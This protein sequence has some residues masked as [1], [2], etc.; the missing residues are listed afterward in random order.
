M[1]DP[2]LIP[3]PAG[4]IETVIEHPAGTARGLALVAHPHPLYGGSMGNKVV[5]T[6]AR[7][8][9]ELGYITVRS[10]FRGVGQT[11][12]QYDEGMGETEDLLAVAR[13]I[14]ARHP[15]LAWS[16]LGFSFG[17]F[18]VQ[19]LSTRLS[20]TRLIMVAPAVSLR[21][22]TAPGAPAHIFQGDADEIIPV[23][24]VAEYAGRINLPLTLIPGAGHF[25]H[26]KLID[27]REAVRAVI[28]AP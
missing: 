24:A 22:F 10:N 6:L 23:A 18:V 3:G 13:F 12:G 17:A 11:E 15:D 27:L 8:L 16:L 7:L 4:A 25:F 2:L 14:H 9:R 26:G 5:T 28:V 19:Q 21:P 20:A 1:P